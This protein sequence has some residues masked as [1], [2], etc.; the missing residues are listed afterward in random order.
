[1]PFP[2]IRDRNYYFL[3][4]FQNGAMIITQGRQF[5]I[6]GKLFSITRAIM[7]LICLGVGVIIRGKGLLFEA[8]R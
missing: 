1:M 7:F 5:D 4:L 2:R 3:F 6:Q 8:I